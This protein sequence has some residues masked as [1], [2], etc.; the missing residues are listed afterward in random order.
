MDFIKA[1]KILCHLGTLYLLVF[2][3]YSNN[4]LNNL[5]DF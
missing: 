5:T 4:F 1:Q 2:K 3:S